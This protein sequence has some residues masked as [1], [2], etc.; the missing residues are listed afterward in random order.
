VNANPFAYAGDNPLTNV[1]PS[2]HGFWSSVGSAL[3]DLGD[4]ASAAWDGISD[5]A[6]DSW[7]TLSDLYDTGFDMLT[8]NSAAANADANKVKDD[9]ARTKADIARH[10]AEVARKLAEARR[11][12]AKAKAQAAAEARKQAEK[13]K[14]ATVSWAKHHAATIVGFLVGLDVFSDCESILGVA[15]EGVLAVAGA[16]FC[17]ALSG[18]AGNFTSLLYRCGVDHQKGGC[19]PNDYL[20]A[21]TSGGLIGAIGGIGGALAG[22]VLTWLFKPVLRK[23]FG[24]EADSLISRILSKKPSDDTPP[25]D[26]A[27]PAPTPKPAPTDPVTPG[28]ADPVTG[29]D[30]AT[31]PDSGAGPKAGDNSSPP[32][33]C[34]SFIA[35]TQVLLA[36]GST[37][38]ISRVKAGDTVTDSVPGQKATEKHKV[39]QTIVTT[40]D[41]DFVDVTLAPSPDSPAAKTW[42]TQAATKLGKTAR[43][44]LA[45][46]AAVA[47][48]AAPGVAHTATAGGTLTTTFLH[49]FYD[50]T[51]SSFIEASKLHI[52]DVLQTPTGTAEVTGLR[53]YH[54]TQTT[55]DLTISGLHTYYV[56]A[57]STPVLVHN[58]KEADAL[59]KAI[60]AGRVRPTAPVG[61][62]NSAIAEELGWQDALENGEIGIQGPGKVTTGGPDFITYHPESGMIRVWDA[63][64]GTSPKQLPVADYW[65]PEVRAAVAAYGGP[66]AAEI[67]N[68][69]ANGQVESKIFRYIVQGTFGS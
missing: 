51:Q 67:A 32:P 38:D 28:S 47:V 24:S 4:A 34:H 54:A 14:N 2:G 55:Y 61:H 23:L 44:A 66:S 35:G 12:A 40:T 5:F 25:P 52:G 50:E 57:G 3:S 22:K 45:T 26:T 11:A 49:P 20:K 58:C 43:A 46:A 42:V 65:L 39:A 1:D 63:I 9:L 41:H 48:L 15:S 60:D 37:E 27:P 18:A 56:V 13:V 59:R 17:G 31:N 64:A 29:P 21:I 36:D 33:G 30:P 69:L 68:A 8:G 16:A 6:S 10:K 62:L 53:L 7:N 19:G